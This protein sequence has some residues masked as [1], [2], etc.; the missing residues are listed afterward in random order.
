MLTA[1]DCLCAA[2]T[3]SDAARPPEKPVSV[4][5]T[6]SA[7]R[8]NGTT[9]YSNDGRRLHAGPRHAFFFMWPTERCDGGQWSAQ[10]NYQPHF[11]TDVR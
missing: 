11:P 1:S 8:I 7:R 9:V 5:Q 6:A 10:L 2:G 3:Q 4:R